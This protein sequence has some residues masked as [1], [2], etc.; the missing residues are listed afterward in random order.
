MATEKEGKRQA[1][2]KINAAIDE[3]QKTGKSVNIP[4]NAGGNEGRLRGIKGKRTKV[5]REQLNEDGIAEII[6]NRDKTIIPAGFFKIKEK[7][8][9]E[10]T[11]LYEY[12]F[13]WDEGFGRYAAQVCNKE[14]GL[15][16]EEMDIF[17]LNILVA[18]KTDQLEDGVKIE[19]VNKK[20]EKEEKPAKFYKKYK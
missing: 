10:E 8:L 3:S 17:C 20:R 11:D 9:N 7:K 6:H 1:A 12:K 19:Q 13:E 2:E 5:D 15:T 18:Q 16:P 14:E 4:I